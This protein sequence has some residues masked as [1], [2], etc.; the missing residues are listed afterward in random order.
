MTNETT[1]QTM[2]YMTKTA[3]VM[4][5][6]TSTHAN[7]LDSLSNLTLSHGTWFMIT[8]TQINAIASRQNKLEQ[9]TSSQ[10]TTTMAQ[11]E[12]ILTSME[13]QQQWQD[14]YNNYNRYN[15]DWT[16]SP[17]QSH[18]EEETKYQYIKTHENSQAAGN[19]TM[20]DTSMIK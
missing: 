16:F 6:N 14:H 3:T 19:S 7:D 15:Q 11:L 13:E 1:G 2:P 12:T 8:I 18:M 10:L 4:A 5:N 20:E 9:Q 17:A